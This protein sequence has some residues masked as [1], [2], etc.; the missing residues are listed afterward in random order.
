MLSVMPVIY[1]SER[2][3]AKGCEMDNSELKTFIATSLERWQQIKKDF[4]NNGEMA[5]Y[6]EKSYPVVIFDHHQLDLDFVKNLYDKTDYIDDKKNPKPEEIKKE[7]FRLRMVA[8][9]E[10]GTKELAVG[11]RFPVL[12]IDLIQELKGH[13]AIKE[14][15]LPSRAII[16]VVIGYCKLK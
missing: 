16:G 11:V 10:K 1:I 7:E 3:N 15:N 2:I 4:S 6:L 5:A 12:A 9:F 14:M 13:S 8:Y